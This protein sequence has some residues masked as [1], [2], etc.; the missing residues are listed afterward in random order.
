VSESGTLFAQMKPIESK[1]NFGLWFGVWYDV[2]IY[3]LDNMLITRLLLITKP[4][5]LSMVFG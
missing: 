1:L 5:L 4:E 2:D 3:Q